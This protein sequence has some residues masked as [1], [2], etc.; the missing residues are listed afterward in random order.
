[1]S[2]ILKPQEASEYLGIP[3]PT[4]SNWRYLDRGRL[5]MG[6]K[7]IG[8][9][10]IDNPTRKRCRGYRREALDAWLDRQEVQV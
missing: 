2:Q 9:A 3:V 5:H 6:Q 1:M 7:P 8:P 4:L 10:W